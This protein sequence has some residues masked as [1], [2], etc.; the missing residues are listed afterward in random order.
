MRQVFDHEPVMEAEVVALFAPVPPGVVVDATVGGGGHARAILEA[1]PHLRVLGLDRD[2]DAVEAARETL[3]PFGTRATVRHARFDRLAEEA[4]PGEADRSDAVSGVLFDLGVSSPQFDRAERGFSY[5]HD[6]PLDMRMD[7]TGG[8]SAADVV[9]TWP[10]DELRRLFAANGE[11]R[12]ATRIA[13]AVV[14]ARPLTTTAQ[15]AAAVTAAIPAAVRRHGGHPARRVF[16]AVRIAVNEELELLAETLPVAIGLVAPRGRCVAIAYHSGE[17]RIVKAAFSEAE[18][19]GCVCPPGLPCACG[20]VPVGRLVFR[21]ARRPTAEE[22]ARNRRA[23]SARLRA[24][25][26]IET[27]GTPTPPAPATGES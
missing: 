25:E 17:D 12:F 9:N 16:Q 27:P 8:P 14:G 26:R 13:R 21:G 5:R 20:A 23:G 22:Q 2:L 24:L 4:E 3:A 10:V 7:A 1:H 6:G 19:G 15:F 18:T 11:G